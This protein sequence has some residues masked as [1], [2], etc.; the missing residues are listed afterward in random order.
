MNHDQHETNMTAKATGVPLLQRLQRFFSKTRIT[1]MQS[2][3]GAGLLFDPGESNPEYAIGTNEMPVQ[4]A[5]A[6]HLHPGDVF[7]DIGAN[8]GFFSVIGARLVDSQG[9]VY[10]FEP[11]PENA[12]VVRKNCELNMLT[13]VKVLEMAVADNSGKGQLQLAQYS[14]GS[15]LAVAAPPPDLKGLLVVDVDTIDRMVAEG[16]LKPPSLVKI[17]VEGAEMHVL[18]GMK[19]TIKTYQPVILLELDDGER[20][21]FEQKKDMCLKFLTELDYQASILPNS[22]PGGNWI[23]EN[24]I[25]LPQNATSNA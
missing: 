3:V 20:E 16:Q 5:L 11:V 25:G 13:Q 18:R 15:A 14:G 6:E 9:T 7:Y 24:F 1:P 12:A 21:P 10:A 4:Q 8:V 19:E 2:G 23:V 22:Y 17:D